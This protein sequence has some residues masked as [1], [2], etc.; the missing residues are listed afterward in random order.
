MG[1]FFIIFFISHIQAYQDFYISYSKI[2]KFSNSAS[3][4]G[5]ID[6]N[7]GSLESKNQND[8]LSDV[9]DF[10]PQKELK[11]SI[12]K[13]IEFL[14]G[15]NDFFCKYPARAI[16]INENFQEIPKKSLS[17]CIEYASWIENSSI[18]SISFMYVTGYLKNPASFL[19]IHY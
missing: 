15:D 3:W 1:F 2:T 12:N 14:K 16:F 11:L 17:N 7:K 10:S 9:Q 18:Q 5:I 19:G 13:Y 4:H 8:Y 6:F